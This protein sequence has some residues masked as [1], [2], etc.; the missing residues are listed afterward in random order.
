MSNK[1][2]FFLILF[3]IFISCNS[4]E[5]NV[6]DFKNNSNDLGNTIL[7]T[8]LKKS[9]NSFTYDS[10]RI[11]NTIGA[12]KFSFVRS[13][14]KSDLLRVCNSL[15]KENK[16]Y[17]NFSSDSIVYNLNKILLSANLTIDD[18][19]NVVPISPAEFC[20]YDSCF[21]LKKISKEI[22]F[23]EKIFF[24]IS[25]CSINSEF[26]KKDFIKLYTE[27]FLFQYKFLDPSRLGDGYYFYDM[28]NII[29][30]N[31]KLFC[32]S[33]WNQLNKLKNINPELKSLFN[34]RCL[35]NNINEHD[36]CE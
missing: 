25:C 11:I 35:K 24:S 17:E 31:K 29:I 27:M 19:L 2:I 4:N 14:Y 16:L 33:I 34:C 1:I 15:F 36:F 23:Y 32:D 13:N 18:L 9:D 22:G 5:N 6:K 21:S 10:L 12:E 8:I 28:N 20:I 30:N 3:L 26:R 7:D